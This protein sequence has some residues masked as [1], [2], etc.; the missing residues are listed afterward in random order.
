MSA[1]SPAKS[2]PAALIERIGADIVAVSRD[3]AIE[4]RLNGTAQQP[5]FGTAKE[6]AESIA[7]QRAYHRQDRHRP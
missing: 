2:V 5:T 7:A 6:F 1:C 3:K 4:D